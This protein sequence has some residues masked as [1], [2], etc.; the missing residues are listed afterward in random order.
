MH[1]KNIMSTQLQMG[2]STRESSHHV[3]MT[4]I[5]VWIIGIKYYMKSRQESAQEYTA[6]SDGWVQRLENLLV[7]MAK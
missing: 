4:Q 6:Q 5:L 3:L 1:T 2:Y 7:F